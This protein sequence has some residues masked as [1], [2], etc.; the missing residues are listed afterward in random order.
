ME[1]SRKLLQDLYRVA[2]Q[3]YEKPAA[4]PASPRYA[5]CSPG[6][7]RDSGQALVRGAERAGEPTVR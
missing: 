3:A 4:L 1:F 2:L 5:W 7:T 6:Y